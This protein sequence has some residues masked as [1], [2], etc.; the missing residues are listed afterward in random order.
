MGDESFDTVLDKGALDALMEPEVGT[1]L[2]S[3]YLS[4]VCVLCSSYRF[5]KLCAFINA[6]IPLFLRLSVFSNLG[7]SLSV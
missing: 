7:E 5:F 4:E 1:K 2:G 6:F 3:Q